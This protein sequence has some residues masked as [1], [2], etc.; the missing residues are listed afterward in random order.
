MKSTLKKLS[1]P[2]PSGGF[3]E[4]YTEDF[5]TQD[6][7]MAEIEEFRNLVYKL[8]FEK[9]EVTEIHPFYIQ[10]LEDENVV[11]DSTV[12]CRLSIH[13]ADVEYSYRDEWMS[14]NDVETIVL[15]KGERVYFRYVGDEYLS[16]GVEDVVGNEL[17]LLLTTTTKTFDVGGDLRTIVYGNT[18]KESISG[19]GLKYFFY[20]SNVVN[21]DK[22]I[23]TFKSV[24]EEGCYSMFSGCTSLTQAPELPATTLES[25]C[26]GYMFKECTSLTQ[27]P[28]LPAT[29]LKTFCYGGMFQGCTSLTQAPEL[30]ATTLAK[31][32]YGYMFNGCTG[33][34]QAPELPVTTLADVCYAS[35]FRGCTSLT[36]SPELPATTLASSCYEYMFRDC[37]SLTQ[38]PD[39]PATTLADNCYSD[40]FQGCTSLTQAPELPEQH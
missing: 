3:D 1:I 8:H 30:P 11:Y 10:S 23:M 9:D 6:G 4:L 35:M 24:G 37:T 36:K 22:L 28:E 39:L 13:A 27:A 7:L 12:T 21:A 26:Y 31:G 25:S 5:V 38:A 29:T 14:L 18:T 17:E 33:L 15:N 34:T 19:N 32:C 20:N 40:M 16:G 2:K